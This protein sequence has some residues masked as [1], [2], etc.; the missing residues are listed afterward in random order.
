VTEACAAC[1]LDLLPGCNERGW[2]TNLDTRA[3]SRCPNYAKGASERHQAEAGIPERFRDARLSTFE[4][5]GK[6]SRQLTAARAACLAWI[7]A[8]V[9]G[10]LLWGGPGV[11]KSHLLSASLRGVLREHPE[12]TGRFVEFTALCAAIQATFDERYNGPRETEILAPLYGA[13]VVVLDELGARRATPFTTDTLYLLVNHLYNHRTPLLV[14][15]NY[16]PEGKGKDSLLERVGE[17]RI[18]SRLAEM[19]DTLPLD[20]CEDYR[21]RTKTLD[22]T[23]QA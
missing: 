2:V 12:M 7:K 13:S 14:S 15:T 18:L 5:S 3:A 1:S 11:G 6:G 17:P 19:C 22:A 4:V 23:V 16:D 9:T 21:R 10:L 8:P 20:R